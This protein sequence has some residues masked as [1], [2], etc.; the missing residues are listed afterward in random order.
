MASIAG[1]EVGLPTTIDEVTPQWLT[2]VFRTS[3]ALA[4]D[5]SVATV[6]TDP[7]AVGVGLLSLLY[8][9]TLTYEGAADRAPATVIVKMETDIEAQRGIADALQFYQREMRFYRELAPDLALRTPKVHAAIMSESNTD[10]CLVMEDLSAMAAMDQQA[11]VSLEEALVSAE[12]MAAFHAH[13]WRWDFS[14]L[15]ETFLPF[16]NPIYRIALPSIFEAGWGNTLKHAGHLVPDDVRA[17]GDRFGELVPFF[18]EQVGEMETLIHGDWRADNLMVDEHG[19]LVL[20]DFQITGI[21]AAGYDLG[22]FLSQSVE[23]EVRREGQQQ[24]ID[25]YFSTLE[26]EGAPFDRAEEERVIRLSTA[27]CLIYAVASFASWDD[28]PD[29]SREL[30]PAMLRRSVTAITD[31]DALSLLPPA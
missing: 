9:A 26:A 4:E 7:F 5:G 2:S 29:K 10:F 27:W 31:N 17:F 30:L 20:I 22:Y 14:D 6:S 23:P 13:F 3:G 15:A 21:G 8:R 1:T 16:D 12:G 11:G 19:K 24:I 18:V 25:R 28:L